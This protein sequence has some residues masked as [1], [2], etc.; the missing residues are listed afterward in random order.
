[1]I[2]TT[3]EIAELERL[4]PLVTAV[5]KDGKRALELIKRV[6]EALKDDKKIHLGWACL[7]AVAESLASLECPQNLPGPI[8]RG[9]CIDKEL[10]RRWRDCSSSQ[11]QQ[12]MFH[13]LSELSM[14]SDE[15]PISIIAL[16]RRLCEST[17]G[18]AQFWSVHTQLCDLL[19]IPEQRR[20]GGDRA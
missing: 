17:T 1:M 10:P 18:T 6:P 3:D 16:I 9:K 4:T 2:F 12:C 14:P 19:N 11:R 13:I 20:A 5:G 15:S 7:L 8:F